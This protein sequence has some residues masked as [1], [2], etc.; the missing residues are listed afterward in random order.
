MNN[1]STTL[2]IA[3]CRKLILRVCQLDVT[4]AAVIFSI[5][6]VPASCMSRINSAFKISKANSTPG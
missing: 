4:K 6:V 5:E 3:G 2:C 1:E